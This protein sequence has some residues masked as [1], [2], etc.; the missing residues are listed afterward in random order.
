[1]QKIYDYITA[2]QQEELEALFK[3]IRQKSISASGEGVEECA[4]LLVQM[5]QEAGI[6]AR[7]MPT[8]GLPVVYGQVMTDPD[9]PT[10]LIYGHYDVQPAD[11]LELWQSP[12]FE[13]TIRDGRVYARGSGDNKGQM[14]AHVLAIKAMKATNSF[15]KINV[16]MLFDGEEESGSPNLPAFLA[17][18]RELFRAD[19]A[20]SSD[21]PMHDSGRPVVFYGVRG[22]LYVQLDLQRANRDFHS[23]N[24]GGVVPNPAWELVQLLSTMRDADGRCTIEGF[25]DD[26]LLPSEYERKLLDNIPYDEA[27]FLRETGL[28]RPGMRPGVGFWESLMFQPTFNICG[29]T[30]G[31][32]GPGSKTIIPCQASIKMDMRLVANQDPNDIYAK[33][34]R[35]VEQHN[36]DVKVTHLG[37]YL[38]S[39][40]PADLPV[41]RK[42]VE[43]VRKAYP[44]EPVIWPSLGGSTPDY[45]LTKHLGLPSI[46]VPYAG[47]DENNHAP[48]ENIK[49]KDFFNGIRAT[50][51]VLTD[52]AEDDWRE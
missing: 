6:E 11:P 35:H 26:V 33:F 8:D 37:S 4:E 44:E 15:P 48:N 12:P 16:K 49:L 24:R 46:W 17:K 7:V 10:I 20:Y 47:A 25:Y 41:C 27:E 42:V 31:Y 50:A 22:L 5:M 18:H 13:P 34:L 36:P 43:S 3:L 32:Q 14:I 29:M 28:G 51:T 23:G 2:H 19:V 21:G 40:T 30:S 38:P 9:A 45:I 1:M 39:K 52:L